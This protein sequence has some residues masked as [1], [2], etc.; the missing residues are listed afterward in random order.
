MS[1]DETIYWLNKLLDK[2]FDYHIIEA[3]NTAI[4][5]LQKEKIKQW[6]G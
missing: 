1:I 5:K 2:E 6:E 4:D 3:L